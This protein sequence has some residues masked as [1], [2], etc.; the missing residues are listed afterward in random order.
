MQT[1]NAQK[2]KNKKVTL[3]F[4]LDPSTMKNNLRPY[5]VPRIARIGE[6]VAWLQMTAKASSKPSTQL[7]I[8][9]QFPF[10][11]VNI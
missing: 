6:Q 2:Q 9:R 3:N 1:E 11:S 5:R 4:K 10:K 7:E 8:R